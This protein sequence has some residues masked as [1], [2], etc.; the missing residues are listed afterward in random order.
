MGMESPGFLA[1]W[2]AGMAAMMLPSELP[3]FRL[4]H[5]TTGSARH[6]SLL[7]GGYLAVWLAAGVA[8][9]EAPMLPAAW[10]L[11]AVALY[12]LTPVKRRCLA[13]CRA[14]LAR[15][16]HGWRDGGLGAFRMGVENGLW[17]LGCC[18]GLTAVLVALGMT[19]VL[20]MAAVAAVIFVE[21]ATRFGVGASRLSAV[22]L[23]AGAVLWAT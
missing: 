6:T 16:L 21:K 18:V 17:C 20:L 14:P 11:G 12:Q 22:A 7:A 15:V 3:L 8:A 10:V 4:A 19:N 2:A 5:A 9:M 1:L 23:A 13:V